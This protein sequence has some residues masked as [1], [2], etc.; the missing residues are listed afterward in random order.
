MQSRLGL[1]VEVMLHELLEVEVRQLVLGSQVQNLLQ[2]GIRD[3]VALVSRVLQVVLLD[4]L[5]N[6]PGDLSASQ[7][8]TTS[9]GHEITQLVRQKGRLCETAQSPGTSGHLLRPL[10]GLLLQL[11]VLLL[12]HLDSG[13]HLLDFIENSV[14]FLKDNCKLVLLYNYFSGGNNGCGGLLY[15]NFNLALNFLLF[16][17]GGFFLRRHLMYYES[18]IVL[19][20]LS[21][22][23]FNKLQISILDMRKLELGVG[24][25]VF[26]L[27]SFHNLED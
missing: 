21:F 11:D 5:V 12:K 13:N 3:D 14:E 26:W 1:L 22:R 4:V 2:L 25:L 8:S 24:V 19:S 20:N 16:N 7:G 17:N 10:S 27:R 9:N 6:H 23:V 18:I 15:R